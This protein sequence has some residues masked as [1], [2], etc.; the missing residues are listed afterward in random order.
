MENQPS[1]L[2]DRTQRRVGRGGAWWGLILIFVGLIIFAQRAGWLGP[3]YN[4]WAL[5][6]FIPAIATLSGAFYAYQSSG[7]FNA[8]VRSSLGSAVVIFTVAFIFLIGL[9][10]SRWWPLMVLAGG[11]SIFLSGFGSGDW[12]AGSVRLPINMGFWLGLGA[13][14]LGAGFLAINL[15]FYDVRGLVSPNRWWAIPIFVPAAGA[16]INA[17]L[18]A[19]KGGRFGAIIGLV[20]FGLMAAATG[21]IA[22]LGMDWNLLGPVLLILA[23]VGIL[24]GIF[25]NRH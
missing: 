18:L 25:S 20:F 22:F 4:W 17:L 6:I 16:L 2:E 8:A 7:K 9:D 1:S 11:F 12:G 14:L 3:Q 13:M 21:M 15:N 23:G 19:V 10:W 24:I 5:F